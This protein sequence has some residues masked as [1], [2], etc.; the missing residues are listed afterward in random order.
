MP[1]L[2]SLTSSLAALV[3]VGVRK[4]AN[5]FTMQDDQ[6]VASAKLQEIVGDP[7]TFPISWSSQSKP[8]GENAI[9]KDQNSPLGGDEIFFSGLMDGSRFMDKNGDYWDIVDYQWEGMCLIQNVWRPRTQ[10]PVSIQ[11]IRR[12]IHSFKRPG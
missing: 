11:D 6:P 5:A 3:N 7:D 9:D 4:H 2:K 1:D 10:V 12:S 8:A